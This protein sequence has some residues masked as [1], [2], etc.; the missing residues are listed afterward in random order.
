M[1]LALSSPLFLFAHSVPAVIALRMVQGVVGAAFY[2]PA[3]AVTTDLSG[4]EHR[5]SAIARFS[6]FLYAGFAVG[7]TLA[8][9]AISSTGFWPPM[10][11]Q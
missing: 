2:T 4:P 3:A 1:L 6:L 7:P 11:G 10:K 5:A 8:E 9:S